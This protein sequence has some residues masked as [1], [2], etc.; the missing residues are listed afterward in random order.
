[1]A[2]RPGPQWLTHFLE[3]FANAVIQMAACGLV[4]KPSDAVGQGGQVVASAC[5]G[6]EAAGSVFDFRGDRIEL[7]RD[8]V[9][10]DAVGNCGQRVC[11]DFVDVRLD[12]AGHESGQGSDLLLAVPDVAKHP[13]V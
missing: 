3:Q 6:Q 12:H 1:M 2:N 7:P 13:K 4:G 9:T 11:V 5:H 8:L 10:V